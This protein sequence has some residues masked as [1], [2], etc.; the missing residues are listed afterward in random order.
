MGNWFAVSFFQKINYLLT[1]WLTD[2][3][4]D[5]M[6]SNYVVNKQVSQEIISGNLT[7]TISSLASIS[8]CTPHFFKCSQQKI[9][10]FWTG[11][12]K[13]QLWRV[14]SQLF[15]NRLPPYIFPKLSKIIDR[16]APLKKFANINLIKTKPWIIT[17]LQKSIS[18]K[19]KLFGDF[20][21]KKDL[22]Q[23][24]ELQIK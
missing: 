20:I 14:L 2:W 9:P 1:D 7:L 3:L 10:Y 22:I 21:N 16:H 8:Y 17:A 11:L 4:I 19:N 18:I 5:N 24:N 13:I 12:V 6:F 15:C 23:N